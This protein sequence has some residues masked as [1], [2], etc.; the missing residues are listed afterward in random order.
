M[1]ADVDMLQ[2]ATDKDTFNSTSKLFLKKWEIEA[3]FVKYF[4]RQWL[5]QNLHCYLGAHMGSFVTD[6]PVES[7]NRVIK[8][9][10][11]FRNRLP[12]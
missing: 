10:Y 2:A 7:H 4:E 5:T 9:Y 12:L 3:A 1:L 11:S 8:D 6:N